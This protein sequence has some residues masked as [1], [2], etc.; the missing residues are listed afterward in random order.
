M[1]WGVGL[2]LVLLDRVGTRWWG[3]AGWDVAWVQIRLDR[4]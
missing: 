4:D 3:T 1:V 2:L